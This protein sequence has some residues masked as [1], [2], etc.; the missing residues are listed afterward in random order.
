MNAQQIELVQRTFTLA[1][2]L[3][4]EI[5]GCFYQRLFEL[6]PTLRPLF[7]S[8]LKPQGE[9]LMTVLAFAVRGLDQPE[10]IVGSVRRLG[11]RH[12]HYGVQAHHYATVGEAL[13][14]TLGE[15]FGPAFT[16]EV[17]E[18]WGA[19]YQLLAGVMQEAAMRSW[20]RTIWMCC[21]GWIRKQTMPR[22]SN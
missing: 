20:S 2:P 5:A 6:D 18:A 4:E 13:L 8:N 1:A 21:A 9:K 3:A 14:W 11:E 19:A 12:V 17:E 22:K 10:I 7:A 15:L 16:P